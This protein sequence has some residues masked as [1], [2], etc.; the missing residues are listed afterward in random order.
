MHSSRK[1]EEIKDLYIFDSR[2]YRNKKIKFVG[3]YPFHKK[4]SVYCENLSQEE[5]L[6]WLKEASKE[7]LDF[8][9]NVQRGFMFFPEFV[10]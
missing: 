8:R 2:A 4:G 9:K 3:G 1:Y 6:E 10:T 5:L 7:M